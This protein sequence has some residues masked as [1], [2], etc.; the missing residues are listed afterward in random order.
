[1]TKKRYRISR[2][3]DFFPSLHDAFDDR[4]RVFFQDFFRS[5]VLSPLPVSWIRG[6]RISLAQRDGGVPNQPPSVQGVGV[7]LNGIVS[8]RE[9]GCPYQKESNLYILNINFPNAFKS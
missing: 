3:G 1:M 7:V 8:F 6:N 4:I 5:F 2:S 9:S